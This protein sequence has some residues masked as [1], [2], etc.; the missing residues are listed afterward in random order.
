VS[1][2]PPSAALLAANSRWSDRGS[3]PPGKRR[4]RR[5]AEHAR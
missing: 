1:R 5:C 3:R 4:W 2:L